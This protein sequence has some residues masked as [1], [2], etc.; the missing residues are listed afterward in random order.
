M[1]RIKNSADQQYSRQVQG[2]LIDRFNNR[3][4]WWERRDLE[5]RD[6]DIQFTVT[7]NTAGQPWKIAFNVYGQDKYAWIVLQYNN[8][9]DVAE[10]LVPG[11]Q[12]VL[13]AVTRLMLDILNQQVG[14]KPVG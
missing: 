11:K 5:H 14:G 3:L 10:E 9:V 13:P 8:I 1:A 12:L 4:G 2:G 6:D 7:T